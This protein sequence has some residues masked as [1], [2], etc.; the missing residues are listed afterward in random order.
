MRSPGRW[1]LVPALV[2]WISGAANGQEQSVTPAE[3]LQRAVQLH[4][5]GDLTGAIQEYETFLAAYPD[6]ADVR[7]NLGAAYAAVGNTRQAIEQYE[8]ALAIGNSSDPVT[9][10]LNLGIACFK[11]NLLNQA[12]ENFEKVLEERPAQ[13]NAALLLADIQL[14]WGEWKKV[15]EILTPFEQ[16]ESD[17]PAMIYLL[18]TALIRDGQVDRG[19]LITD[20]ILK[21]GDSAEAHL[22][23]GT[24]H[25]MAQDTPGAAEEFKKAVDLNPRLLSANASYGKAL[26]EMGQADEA[27]AY[28]LR[29]LELN[30]YD[31]D[32]N[33]LAGVYLY[34]NEQEYDEALAHFDRALGVRPEALEVKFQVGLVYVLQNRIDEALPIIEEVVEKAPAFLEG[35]VTLAR[36]YYR[37]KRPEDAQRH[38]EIADRIRAEEDSRVV[39]QMPQGEGPPG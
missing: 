3:T 26:L 28:F 27:Q 25:L 5:A 11:A 10:R 39:K 23:L 31:F 1:L 21:K 7:S 29:E 20:K 37:L 19:A 13:K 30:P 22:L 33:L 15:I 38:R 24:A 9:I 17:D 34:K 12:A 32:S 2:G 35:H 4:Q 18:G 6:M 16:E 14:R 36:L 8:K